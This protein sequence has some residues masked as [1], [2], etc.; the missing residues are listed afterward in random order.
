[1]SPRDTPQR[2][3]QA[4]ER[5]GAEPALIHAEREGEDAV[6]LRR[7]RGQVRG[8]ARTDVAT[9]AALEVIAANGPGRVSHDV[10][11]TDALARLYQR[12]PAGRQE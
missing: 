11:L 9:A 8:Q 4:V 7:R 1:M 2:E 6:A 12:P 5:Y 10:V 3:A